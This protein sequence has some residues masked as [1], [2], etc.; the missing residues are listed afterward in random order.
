MVGEFDLVVEEGVVEAGGCGVGSG[1]AVVDGA[2][3]RPVDGGE[4]HGAGLAAGVDLTAGEGEGVELRAGTAD[5]YDLR[6]GG[7]V[8]AGGDEV[9]ADGHDVAVSHDD[10]AEW[11]SAAGEDV[12]GG[13]VDGLLHEDWVSRHELRILKDAKV[14]DNQD[15]GTGL[16]IKTNS[17]AAGY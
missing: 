8:V 13:Q 4:A 7:W 16:R 11:A 6:V 17:D 5:G 1:V 3:A 9:G 14:A 2:E 12:L 10:R 15:Y